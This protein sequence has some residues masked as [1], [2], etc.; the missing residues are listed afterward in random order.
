MDFDWAWQELEAVV[1]NESEAAKLRL[2]R[3][4]GA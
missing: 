3:N 1:P 4:D 2:E